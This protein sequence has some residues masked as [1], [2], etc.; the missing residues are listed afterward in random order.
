[1]ADERL[2]DEQLTAWEEEEGYIPRH[3]AKRLVA[4]VKAL[5]EGL[6]ETSAAL[7][8]TLVYDPSEWTVDKLRAALVRAQDLL[9]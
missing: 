6:R 8:V 2:R 7:E 4:E 1:M 9:P 3:A 5:R